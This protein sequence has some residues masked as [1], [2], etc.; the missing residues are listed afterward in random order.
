MGHASQGSHWGATGSQPGIAGKT[1][2]ALPVLM[3][4][5]DEKARVQA[6]DG[7]RQDRPQTRTCAFFVGR[8]DRTSSP[9]DLQ[10]DAP[11][12]DALAGNPVI[13]PH[14]PLRASLSAAGCL[15]CPLPVGLLSHLRYSQ[16]SQEGLPGIRSR[17]VGLSEY[18]REGRMYLLLLCQRIA[19]PDY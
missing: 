18:H 2:L 14:L 10:L 6:A 17:G 7:Q 5:N 1:S 15:G 9:Q 19:R 8:P 16:G 11:P 4:I 12:Q 3:Q 13:A